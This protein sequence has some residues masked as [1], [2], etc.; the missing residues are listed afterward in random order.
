MYR[1]DKIDI[2]L[3]TLPILLI[4]FVILAMLG[5]Y[6][7][8]KEAYNSEY[9]TI[10]QLQILPENKVVKMSINEK[11]VIKKWSTCN[12]ICINH[13]IYIIEDSTGITLAQSNTSF[14]GNI[15]IYGRVKQ[16]NIDIKGIY[17]DGIIR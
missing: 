12:K 17:V 6:Y 7:E 16:M 5:S 15:T 4:L 2:V 14:Q 13:Y 3:M 10:S 11:N 8:Y 9:I 1:V